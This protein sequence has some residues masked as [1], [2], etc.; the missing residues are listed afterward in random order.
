M[1]G[2]EREAEWVRLR[3]RC[4]RHVTPMAA[5]AASFDLLLNTIPVGHDVNPTW[6][7]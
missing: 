6:P 2:P 5:H 7:C 3:M 4:S 1:V